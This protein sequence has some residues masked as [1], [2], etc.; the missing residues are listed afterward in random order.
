VKTFYGTQPSHHL[1]E[2]SVWHTAQHIRQLQVVLD[3]YNVTLNR[4]IDE[5]KYEG[6]PMPTGVW[7]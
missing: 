4:R 1:L 6:L 3:S 2:H 7:E 5:S